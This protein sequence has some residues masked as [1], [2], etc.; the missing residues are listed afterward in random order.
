MDKVFTT[1]PNNILSGLAVWIVL[2]GVI[3]ALMHKAKGQSI[4]VYQTIIDYTIIGLMA[5]GGVALLVVLANGL[6]KL[7]GLE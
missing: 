2:V 6:K 7:A 3:V 5:T 1:L 4:G